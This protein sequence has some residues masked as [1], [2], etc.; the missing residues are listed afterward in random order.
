MVAGHKN[1]PPKGVPFPA[2]GVSKT[3]LLSPDVLM[4]G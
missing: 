2:L 4:G 3:A 1:E